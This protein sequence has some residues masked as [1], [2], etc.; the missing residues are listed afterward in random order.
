MDAYAMAA[1]MPSHLPAPRP[2]SEIA[3]VINATM[4]I[5]MMKLKKLP[6]RPLNVTNTRAKPG[7]KNNPQP[8]PNTR[9][10]KMRGSR[11]I[12]FMS[13][14]GWSGHAVAAAC[15]SHAKR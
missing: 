3:G 9:A 5:G 6:N 15:G 14:S 4:I 12:L 10:I 7:G 11:P 13:S 8:M 2:N 1:V